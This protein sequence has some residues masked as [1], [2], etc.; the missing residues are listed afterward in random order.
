MRREGPSGSGK[1]GA[2]ET[3]K[4]AS[5]LV[6]ALAATYLAWG[7]P[8]PA[9]AQP[10]LPTVP[11]YKCYD[12][13]A[14]P[15]PGFSV[16]LQNQFGVVQEVA[17]GLSTRLCLAALKNGEGDLNA[18]NVECFAIA[19]PLPDR[20]VNLQTQFGI[21]TNVPVGAPNELCVPANIAIAPEL[22]ST[23]L[24]VA[25]HY[26][27]YG[28]TGTSP[29]FPPVTLE[30]Q[31]GVEQSVSVGPPTHLCLPSIKNG[32]GDMNVPHVECFGIAGSPPGPVLNVIS[33]FGP[34]QN[35]AVLSPAEVC[36]PAIKTIVPPTPAAIGGVADAPDVNGRPLAGAASG[37]SLTPMHAAIV[38][39]IA[40]ILLLGAA[41]W[42]AR[43]RWLT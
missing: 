39:G 15:L 7:V 11:H 38:G 8:G 42:Y 20:V 26:E 32:V 22:P 2:K 23:I 36:A 28:V 10:P 19:E 14:R 34:Q 33:Q 24:P 13:G 27:C 3:E 16:R 29:A 40:G 6:A 35:V 25:P 4:I 43:R 9:T 18:P 41:G 21:Q 31:L 1:R 5:A 12:I 37:S 30:T 17:V